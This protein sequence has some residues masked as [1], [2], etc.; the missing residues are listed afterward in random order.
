MRRGAHRTALAL[1][2]AWILAAPGSP[3]RP[4]ALALVGARIY[5]A[6]EGLPVFD[7]TVVIEGGKILTVGPREEVKVPAGARVL[8]CSGLVITAGFQNSHVHFTEEKWSEA[9]AQPASKLE[10]Q[11][12]GMLVRYGFTT[13]VDTASM[14]S[15]TVALRKRIEDGEVAG[16]RIL[17]AGVALYPPK[18]VPFYLRE[19]LP[20]EVVAMLPQ[21]ATPGEAAGQVER[22]ARGGA[23]AIKL[24]TGSWVARGEVLPM[25]REIA[26]AAVT[27]AHRERLPVFTHASNVAGLEVALD[28]GVDIVAHALDD[29]RGLTSQH[30]RRMKEQDVALVPTLA[31]FAG[32]RWFF[33]IQDQVRD[34]ARMGGQ[35]LFGTDVGYLTDYDPQR[36]L[37]LLAGAGLGWREILAALTTNPAA[38]FGEAQRRG[39]IA[40]GLDGDLV[41]LAR[42]PAL[43]VRALADV[44]H[45]VRGGRVIWSAPAPSDGN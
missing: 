41:V 34:F 25:P 14:L 24:F 19:D 3:A 43:D 10:S 27:A 33:E 29:T 6:P 35:V 30:L 12:A 36:E 8:D 15:N 11:L 18:G 16:P 31:L 13:V 5:P 44:R 38:R 26:A 7:G 20:A 28:A 39:R 37:M 21:P 22:N 45:V 42:D 40:P 32:D 2:A 1:L 4:E 9:A 23:D 17:T